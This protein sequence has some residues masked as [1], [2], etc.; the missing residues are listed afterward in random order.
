MNMKYTRER[1]DKRKTFVNRYEHYNQGIL[2]KRWIVAD[3]GRCLHYVGV[4]KD[5]ANRN[6]GLYNYGLGTPKYFDTYAAARDCAKFWNEKV[7]CRYD[8]MTYRFVPHL[9]KISFV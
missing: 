4:C 3:N 6:E 2:E 5:P 8:E 7:I 1:P 9:V